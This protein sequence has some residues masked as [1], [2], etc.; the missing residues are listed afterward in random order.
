[1]PQKNLDSLRQVPAD[2]IHASEKALLE[3]NPQ[4]LILSKQSVDFKFSTLS[5][6]VKTDFG[7]SPA[8]PIKLINDKSQKYLIVWSWLSKAAIG[9]VSVTFPKLTVF[10][11]K[12]NIHKITLIQTG[13]ENGCGLTRCRKMVYDITS[14]PSGSY[15]I[16]LVPIVEDPEKALMLSTITNGTLYPPEVPLYADYF[17]DARVSLESKLP[18]EKID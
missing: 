15:D 11:S 2:K 12:M 3:K 16:V 10:D 13:E 14:L 18:F 17:G 6:V 5:P 7:P 1:M 4:Q 8:A 9:K